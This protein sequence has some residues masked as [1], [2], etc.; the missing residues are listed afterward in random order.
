MIYEVP[1]GQYSSLGKF[2][3][4]EWALL[5]KYFNVNID[6]IIIYSFNEDEM[7]NIEASIGYKQLDFI[8]NSQCLYGFE[9]AEPCQSVLEYL[10]DYK[11]SIDGG[12]QLI[13]LF[14]KGIVFS[15]LELD[16][17]DNFLTLNLSS[18]EEAEFKKIFPEGIGK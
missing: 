9:I 15:E 5:F 12:I 7:L 16:D 2:D 1:I 10:R 11:Y 18:D 13:Y 6:R 17:S 3:C 8:D 14:K 4:S